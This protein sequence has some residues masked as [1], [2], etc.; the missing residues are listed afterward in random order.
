MTRNRVVHFAGQVNGA[1]FKIAQLAKQSCP[2]LGEA[3]LPRIS[4]RKCDKILRRAFRYACQMYSAA[5]PDILSSWFTVLD[6]TVF[7]TQFLDIFFK[8]NLVPNYLRFTYNLYDIISCV[9]DDIATLS[10]EDAEHLTVRRI[11]R[12][13]N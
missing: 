1:V 3:I 8:E 4:A 11:E 5:R 7:E 2:S 12:Q 13:Q 10:M 9:W 6:R